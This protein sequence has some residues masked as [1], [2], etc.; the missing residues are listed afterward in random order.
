M[1]RVLFVSSEEDYG[2]SRFEAKFNG[3]PVLEIMDNLDKYQELLEEDE[4]TS[5]IE[6]TIGT[7]E[8]VD[9]K[10]FNDLLGLVEYDSSKDQFAF[11]Q[12]GIIKA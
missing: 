9:K 12:E 10:L 5:D 11:H 8:H 2:V 4:E 7:Y 3:K 6:L 1:D